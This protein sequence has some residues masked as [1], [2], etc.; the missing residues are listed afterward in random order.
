MGLREL[1]LVSV[2]R[3]VHGCALS[4]HRIAIASSVEAHGGAALSEFRS[5]SGRHAWAR[6]VRGGAQK[7][8]DRF[9]YNLMWRRRESNTSLKSFLRENKKNKTFIANLTDSPASSL[10]RRSKSVAR[11]KLIQPQEQSQ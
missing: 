9:A 2:F 8:I 6:V 11:W 3:W 4:A 10:R 5:R 1:E 7:T